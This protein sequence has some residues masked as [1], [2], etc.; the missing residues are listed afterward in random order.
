MK[1]AFFRAKKISM[2]NWSD[3][4]LATVIKPSSIQEVQFYV[5]EARKPTKR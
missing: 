1:N 4:V 5:N 3:E 2:E